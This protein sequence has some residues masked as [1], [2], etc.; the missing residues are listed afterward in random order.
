MLSFHIQFKIVENILTRN[1]SKLHVLNIGNVIQTSCLLQSVF[2]VLANEKL[3]W[4]FQGTWSVHAKYF[5]G[6]LGTL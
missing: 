2:I 4:H 5:V 1:L 6:H 3:I